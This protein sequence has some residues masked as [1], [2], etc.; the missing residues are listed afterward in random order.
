MTA[1][2]EGDRGMTAR[3]GGAMA[4][5]AE[6]GRTE[7]A[8]VLGPTSGATARALSVDYR[9]RFDEAGPDGLV[10]PGV[11]LAYAQDCA[12]LHSTALGFDRAWYAARRLAWLVRAVRL[13][14]LTPIPSGSRLL[15]RTEVLGFRAASARRRTDIALDG[16]R[17]AAVVTDWALTDELGRPARLPAEIRDRFGAQVGADAGPDAPAGFVPLRLRD[18]PASPGRSAPAPG[19]VDLEDR[20][21]RS[22]A[23]P[24]GH[25][26]NGRA[27]DLVDEVLAT[28]AAGRTLLETLP[29][30]YIVEY[31][32][33]LPASRRIAAVV[34]SVEEASGGSAFGVELRDPE[35]A[36]PAVVAVV[37]IQEGSTA[38][39]DADEDITTRRT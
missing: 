38:T 10:R 2:D 27:I 28:L 18:L 4:E 3:D 9:V 24:M 15:V 14:L 20:V 11:L 16:R 39:P 32:A 33:P 23:D 35:A 37:G 30:R 5:A 17:V 29:R 6:G 12:W 8:D 1:R 31:R 21:R 34:R 19:G 13:D 22:D 26:N 25:L 7:P 36:S